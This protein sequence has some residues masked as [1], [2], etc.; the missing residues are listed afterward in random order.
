MDINKLKQLIIQHSE[1]FHCTGRGENSKS[2]QVQFKHITTPPITCNSLPDIGKLNEFY[3]I[4][5][6]LRL[7][8]DEE[9]GDSAYY[10]ANPDQWE[11]LQM[12]FNER[13][14]YLDED[15]RKELLPDWIDTFIVIGE[16]PNTG[17]YLLMPTSGDKTGYVIEFDHDGFEFTELGAN[18]AESVANLLNP[19]ST[20][21]SC[22]AS[23]MTF[24]ESGSTEQWWIEEMSDSNGNIVKTEF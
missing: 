21:L 19:N 10:I 7:Y 11:T 16:I 18:I 2:K 3:S 15:E 13:T 4:F 17:N 20:S 14:D 9:T 23:Y 22:I 6:D 5:G 8:H 1:T 24:I 12:Y